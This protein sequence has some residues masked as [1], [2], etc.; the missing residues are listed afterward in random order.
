MRTT[1][2]SR[3]IMVPEAISDTAF[4]VREATLEVTF[5]VYP[6]EPRTRDHPGS[7]PEAEDTETWVAFSDGKKRQ[8]VGDDLADLVD[9]GMYSFL[10]SSAIQQAADE[11]KEEAE[12]DVEER[13]ERERD[14][15]TL[16]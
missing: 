13:W 7:S 11:A 5:H 6:G 4:V 2:V 10:F 14:E 9:E 1:T 15:R 12:C 3:T 16:K 8:L